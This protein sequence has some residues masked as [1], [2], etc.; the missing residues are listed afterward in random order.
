MDVEEDTL[1]S[2]Q[3]RVDDAG[4]NDD[5]ML[6]RLGCIRDTLCLVLSCEGVFGIENGGDRNWRQVCGKRNVKRMGGA[7]VVA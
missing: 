5:E 7:A 6:S 1:G 4:I 2:A 3:L